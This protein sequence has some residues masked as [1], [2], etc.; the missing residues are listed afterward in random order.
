[1]QRKPHNGA[2]AGSL[3]LAVFL[4]GDNK[5]GIKFLVNNITI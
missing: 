2:L 4:F 5:T 3:L 1:V